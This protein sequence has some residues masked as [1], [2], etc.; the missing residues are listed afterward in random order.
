MTAEE[1]ERIDP[2]KVTAL[3]A[4]HADELQA[5][6]IGV[7]RDAELAGEVVQATFSKTIESGHTAKQETMKGWLFRVAFN[8]AMAIRRRQKVH[9]KSIQKLAWT[10]PNESESPE[11]SVVRWEVVERVKEAMKI[12]P[13]EQ[14]QVVRMRIYEE[15]TFA[16]IAEELSLPLGTV[17]TR[18]RLAMQKLHKQLESGE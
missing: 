10:K 11:V 1:S 17:L 16:V 4:E 3:Y 5:F 8:E 9:V 13:P 18:M 6:L 14:R 7:L 15:K 2:E 12:L